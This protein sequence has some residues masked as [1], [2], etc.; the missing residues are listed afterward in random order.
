MT[1]AQPPTAAER[2][3]AVWRITLD[4]WALSGRELPT[5]TRDQMPIRRRALGDE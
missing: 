4:A 5:Y 2:V 3:A 1:P